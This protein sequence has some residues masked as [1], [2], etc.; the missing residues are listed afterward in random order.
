MGLGDLITESAPPFVV[1]RC[2]NVLSVTATVLVAID[3][4][5]LDILDVTPAIGKDKASVSPI[6][7]GDPIVWIF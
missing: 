7:L 5:S 2:S 3:L 6:C 4:S 1:C